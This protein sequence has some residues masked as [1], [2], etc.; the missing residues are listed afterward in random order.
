MMCYPP[1]GYIKFILKKLKLT[2]AG[3]RTLGTEDRRSVPGGWG[4]IGY[5]DREPGM[6]PGDRITQTPYFFSFL[7]F[8]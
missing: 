8:Q 4:P 3:G 2:G 5:E 1:S 7:D 6:K